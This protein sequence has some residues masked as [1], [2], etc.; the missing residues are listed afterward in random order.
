MKTV[1]CTPVLLSLLLVLGTAQAWAEDTFRLP[2]F[3]Q[4]KAQHQSS[5]AVLLDRNGVILTDLRIDP[6]VRRLGWVPLQ[7]LSPAMRVALLRAEDHRFFE[8][9][10]VDWLAFAGAAWQNLWSKN[11]RGASTLTMQ[12]AGLLDPALRMPQGKGAR[13]SYSQKWDQGRAALE[14]E[15]QWNKGQI[16][17]AYLNLAPFRGDL[18]GVEAASE[19]L[20]GVTAG[21]LNSSQATLLAVLLRGP[22]ASPALVARRAC[23]L[24]A[25]LG[26]GALC[27]E[28]TSLATKRLDAPRNQPRHTLA[29]QLARAHLH[30]PGQRLSTLLDAGM[31][32]R[33][34]AVLGKFNDPAASAILLDNASGDV[35]AWIGAVSP[36]LPDEVLSPRLPVDWK[37]PVQVALALEQRRLTLATPLPLGATIFDPRDAMAAPTSWMSLRAALAGHQNGALLEV[38]KLN[39]RDA[40]L[41]RIHA[42]GLLSAGLA[43]QPDVPADLNLLQIASIWRAFAANGQYLPPRLL[44]TDVPGKPRRVWKPEVSFLLQDAYATGG[45]GGWQTA[46]LL[47]TQNGES[48]LVGNTDRHTLALLIHGPGTAAELRAALL[49]VDL[50][51]HAPQMPEGLVSMPVHF[52]P[53]DEPPRR[54]WFL[55]GTEIS[56]VTVLPDWRVARITYPRAGEHYVM[57]QDSHDRWALSAESS[58]ALRWFADGL[59]LGTGTRQSWLPQPGWHRMSIRNAAD[60]ELDSVEF[61]VQAGGLPAPEHPD[62]AKDSPA[63]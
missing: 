43:E 40:W 32:S 23:H 53:P 5:D 36:A 27:G 60:Q 15:H 35:L 48:L 46:W 2:P 61:W 44:Q 62:D 11:K 26:K 30:H 21:Q 1:P 28:I 50:E 19:L 10:G 54:E 24:A 49:A 7:A 37:W 56:T 41:D 52:V 38:Q 58:V 34:L 39:P 18:Q 14:L 3:E 57:P 20:F 63:S 47:H 22:N 25:T 42:L 51:S 12:L 16:L 17:E 31:Q 29:V 13:R 8:H 59:L 6:T 45:E 4:V 55:S 9:S 33:L